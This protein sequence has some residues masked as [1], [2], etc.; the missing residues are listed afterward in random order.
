M[1]IFLSGHGTTRIGDPDDDGEQKD[2]AYLVNSVDC[3]DGTVVILDG[4]LARAVADLR[5]NNNKAKRVV[6]LGDFSFPSGFNNDMAAVGDG[7]LYIAGAKGEEFESG[8]IEN[9]VFTEKFINMGIRECRA[10]DPAQNPHGDSNRKVTMEEAYDY[11]NHVKIPG[12]PGAKPN[13]VDNLTDD[14]HART[15]KAGDTGTC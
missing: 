10:D 9:G 8:Q 3:S 15:A 11:A 6:V 14:V 2:N 12:V 7:V 1:V 5:A 4:E 13:I